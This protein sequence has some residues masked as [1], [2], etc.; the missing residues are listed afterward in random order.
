MKPLRVAILTVS[1]RSAAGTRPDTSGPALEAEVRS[2]GWD[3][4]G[5]RI[6]PDETA[7]ISGALVGWA[8]FGDVDVIL[9]TGG[10]GFAPRDVT[11]EATLAVIEREAPGLAEAMR[12]REPFD[13]TACHA[14]PGPAPACASRL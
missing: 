13:I 6:V 7:K 2:A 11:P 14:C 3:V 9:T 10:T 8:D 5:A 4:V 12:A 1:D